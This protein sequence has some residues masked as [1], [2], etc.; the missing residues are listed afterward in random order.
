MRNRSFQLGR[1]HFHHTLL[2]WVGRWPLGVIAHRRRVLYVN[3]AAAHLLGGERRRD[4][5]G[6]PATIASTAPA[7]TAPSAA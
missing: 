1:L 4:L 6:R 3:E 2:D 5:I 7:H